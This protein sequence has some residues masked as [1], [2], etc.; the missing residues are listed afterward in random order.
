MREFDQL[1]EAL[2]HWVASADLPWRAQS[3]RAAYDKALARTGDVERAFAALDEIQQAL[4]AKD[5]RRVWGAYH[6]AADPPNKPTQ[7]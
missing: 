5:A 2:R 1:P 7:R 3:V 4:V 6:P